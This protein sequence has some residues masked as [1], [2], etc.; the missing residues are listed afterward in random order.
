MMFP[1][2]LSTVLCS[3]P[4]FAR[5]IFLFFFQQKGAAL[6]PNIFS[7]SDRTCLAV[8]FVIYSRS[9]ERNLIWC[10]CGTKAG[11]FEL[12]GATAN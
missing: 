10:S 7:G 6:V 2:K 9:S 1:N 4:S 12:S 8:V 3:Q 11:I 5:V